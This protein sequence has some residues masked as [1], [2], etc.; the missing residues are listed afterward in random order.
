MFKKQGTKPMEYKESLYLQSL[1]QMNIILYPNQI[2]ENKTRENIRKS[3]VSFIEGKCTK[4]GYVQPNSID[5]KS[6]SSGIVKGDTIEFSVI[7]NCNTSNPAENTII[8]CIVKSI[9]KAGIHAEAFDEKGNI[10]ITIFVARDHY[11][12]T[13]DFQN[14]KEHEKI[15]IKVIGSRFELNDERIEVLGEIYTNYTNTT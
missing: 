7:F 1:L 2:G 3:L 12:K 15:Q 10:P 11:V 6:Y 5:I 14:I 8:H 9:T 4:E 13:H